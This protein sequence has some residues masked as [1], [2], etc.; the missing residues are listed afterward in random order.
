M[1]GGANARTLT[2]DLATN[3]ITG[4][5]SSGSEIVDT[6][7]VE[8]IV[9]DGVGASRLEVLG[10]PNDDRIC[11]TPTGNQAGMF[12]LEDASTGYTFQG[13]AGTFQISGGSGDADHLVV[14]GTD[15]HD[16][17]VIDARSGSRTVTVENA[18]GSCSSRSS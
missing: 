17:V 11:Y 5:G 6:Q 12:Q 18:A 3:R 16:R 9:L 2:V 4:F 13:A 10:T 8:S 1:S 7:G 15:S 14:V